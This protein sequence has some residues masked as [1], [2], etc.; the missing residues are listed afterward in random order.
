MDLTGDLIAK[1]FRYCSKT[2]LIIDISRDPM[3]KKKLLQQK[4]KSVATNVFMMQIHRTCGEKIK[5]PFFI[6]VLPPVMGTMA[7]R[8]SISG[9]QWRTRR[10]CPTQA[11]G[12]VQVSALVEL[13][14]Y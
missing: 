6:A 1:T 3:A 9:V 4:C 5:N 10:R 8:R 14:L 11:C 13:A 12:H 7:S 2:N